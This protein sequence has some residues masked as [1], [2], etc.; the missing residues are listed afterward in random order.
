MS[1]RDF[2]REGL[3]AEWS[4][5]DASRLVKSRRIET[6][7]VIVGTGAGGA[8]AAEV[9]TTAG[10][11]VVLVE[12]GVFRTTR[13]FRMEEVDAYRWQLQEGGLRRTAAGDVNLLQGRMAGGSTAISWGTMYDPPP[14]TLQFWRDARDVLA[15]NPEMLAPVLAQVRARLRVGP[16]TTQRNENNDVLDQGCSRLG[17]HVDRM[18]RAVRGC[19][20][21]GYCSMGCPTNAMQSTLT[22][23][24][25]AVLR[26][27]AR[28]Y[29]RLRCER[30]VHAKGRVE[31][32][33]C[34]ALE[35]NGVKK[36]G[37]TIR[38]RARHFI[39]AAGGLASPGILLRSSVPDP[40]RRIGR[41]TF[42]HPV[43]LS[44]A[45]FEQQVDPYHGAPQSAQCDHFLFPNGAVGRMGFR[46]EAL[47][48]HPVLWSATLPAVGERH[49]RWMGELPHTNC[50]AALLRDG[51]DSGSQGGHVWLDDFRHAHLSYPFT[52][53]VWNGVRRA[54]L[55][56]AEIQFAAGARTVM[57][58]HA[59]ARP[60]ARYSEARSAIAALAPDAPRTRFA[61]AH[62]MGGCAMGNDPQHAVTNSRGRFH[63]LENLSVM[64][65][66]LFPTSL[67]A[68]PQLTIIAIATH[69]A[70]HL[71]AEL[72]PQLS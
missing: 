40:Y 60:Y 49:A 31:E 9:L 28:L 55:A 42:L 71:A 35:P 32:M 48:L 72:Q 33:V 50:L 8:S 52:D 39:L 70:D 67:G 12:E 68:S 23:S 46:I 34:R 19:W 18:E 15:L 27:G 61:S 3:E 22:T 5:T 65:G 59:D 26:E 13:D 66:S 16:W 44:R 57:P 43:V 47:P 54:W 6:D 10:L 56:M 4:V 30:L 64:D 11:K 69:F 29:T 38:I 58:V 62:V 2:L 25:P 41:R 53:Y 1:I 20:N 24:L 51:F 21:L 14:E 17:W 7:V 45:L 63:H 37:V 36:T